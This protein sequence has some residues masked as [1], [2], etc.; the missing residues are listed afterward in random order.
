[1]RLLPL[2]CLV[3]VCSAV[4]ASASTITVDFT[5]L[6]AFPSQPSNDTNVHNAPVVPTNFQ[7]GGFAF[8]LIIPALPGYSGDDHFHI[9]SP[10]GTFGSYNGTPYIGVHQDVG[11]CQEVLM[12]PV[13]GGTFGLHSVDLAEFISPS[14]TNSAEFVRVTGVGGVAPQMNL[15]LDL[16]SDGPGGADDFQTFG[17][18]PE[19][20]GLTAVRF[21]GVAG[22]FASR[23]SIG[24]DN[25]VV[26]TVPEPTSLV[27]LGTS[28]MF[29]FTR[30]R[31][32]K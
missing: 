25:V 14:L 15:M 29:G 31:R 3:I 16:V 6:T 27:L 4:P 20:S 17:F 1:M 18:G 2:A 28:L 32:W 12:S 8:A 9:V 19:W 7:S 21:Q 24:F 11:C 13:G 26:T 10:G 23:I 22:H 5:D 30:Y